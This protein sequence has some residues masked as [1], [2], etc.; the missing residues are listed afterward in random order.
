[1][2]TVDACRLSPT[3]NHNKYLWL[4][5]MHHVILCR[6]FVIIK[7]QQITRVRREFHKHAASTEIFL[8]ILLQCLDT[9]VLKCVYIHTTYMMCIAT[10]VPVSEHLPRYLYRKVA[11]KQNPPVESQNGNSSDR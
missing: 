2:S 5:A 8:E 1:M 10:D 4:Y 11:I 9:Y 7:L 6:A 3:H